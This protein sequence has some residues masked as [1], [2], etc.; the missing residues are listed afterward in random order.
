M[1][2][3]GKAA[4]VACSNGLSGESRPKIE[5]LKARLKEMG[6]LPVEMG[7]L[8]RKDTLWSGTAK[9]R[10]KA[11]MDCY[12]DPDIRWVFD[13]SG[14][15]L[16][17][18]ILPWLDFERIKAEEK[19]FW[20]Y[21]DLTTIVN[22][23]FA[24]T[25]RPAVLYQVRNLVGSMGETQRKRFREALS[26]ESGELFRIP[27]RFLRGE[28]LE[29]R[30]VGGNIR[31]LLKLAGTPFWPDM[32]GKVLLLEALG[33]TE[34]QMAAYLSQLGQM[35]VWDQISGVL[36]GTFTQLEKQRCRPSMEELVLERAARGSGEALPVAKTREVGHGE[37]SRAVIIGKEICCGREDSV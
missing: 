14:G 2:E 27:C 30:A 23:I 37:D 10:A 11:L 18:E 25:G 26:G 24:K 28:K 17:N 22:A 5:E 31:C 19:T 33:G 16:A 12:R 13:V 34:A 15:D 29:G 36:L 9:E 6:L 8:Y 4:I 21:S 35:G 1:K 32:N 20:G 7:S 3:K